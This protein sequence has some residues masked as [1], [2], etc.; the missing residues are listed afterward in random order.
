MPRR[1]RLRGG[2]RSRGSW[3]DSPLNSIWE[4]SGNVS[5]LDVLRALA[6]EPEALPAFLAE[7][8]LAPRRQ[9]RASMPLD[10]LKGTLPLGIRRSRPARARRRELAVTLQASLLVRNGPPAGADAFCASRLDGGPRRRLRDAAAVRG[11]RGHRGPRTGRLSTLRYEVTA[12]SPGSRSNRPERGNGD[13][14]RHAARAGRVRGAGEPRPGRHVIAL[15]GNGKGFCGGYDLVESPR[16]ARERRQRLAARPDD[17][18]QPRPA[19]TWDPVVDWQMMS[20][21]LRGFMSLFHS[22]KPVV[23]K[24]HGFC[25]AGGTDMA[26]C[27]DLLVIADDARIGY[28]PARVWGVADLGAV[29]LPDRRP[30]RQAAAVHRRP[31]RRRRGARVGPRDRGAAGRRARRALRGA[32][33]AHRA[34]AREPAR[35]DEAARQPGAVRAGPAGH[36]GARASSSTASPATRRR[37]T[38]FQQRA[39]EAGFKEAVRERDEPYDSPESGR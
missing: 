36:A 37:A 18:G 35:D 9:R 30:A 33:G 12:A 31:D 15:S 11:C 20:R 23:C 6:K 14:A 24:V 19:S 3:R 13:H 38:R 2:V 1:Q 7:C 28:P 39:A 5:A 17:R 34:H 22:D 16:A 21:N 25:V 27:S 4:G 29:G 10:R 8:E 32:G 26:L